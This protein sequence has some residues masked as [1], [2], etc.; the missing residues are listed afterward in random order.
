MRMIGPLTGADARAYRQPP[1]A[2]S[3][4][5]TAARARMKVKRRGRATQRPTGASATARCEGGCRCGCRCARVDAPAPSTQHLSHVY[6]LSCSMTALACAASGDVGSAS[7]T[8][9]NIFVAPSL[10]PLLSATSAE[11]E[12]RLA[13]VRI[14]VGRLLV[15]LG[16][17]VGLAL[18]E[19]HLAEVVEHFLARAEA[20]GGGG[21][22]RT[23]RRPDRPS[24]GSSCR[25]RSSPCRCSDRS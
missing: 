22:R 15:P 8:F 6:F 14:R 5:P 17:F 3:A 11:L 12:D 2:A 13:P 9:S 16:R 21:Q 24:R 1:T 18:R 7:M 4:V 25:C 23:R 20:L 10:S 19:L